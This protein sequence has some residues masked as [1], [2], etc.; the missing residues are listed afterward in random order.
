MVFLSGLGILQQL[1]GAE[2]TAAK[3]EEDEEAFDGKSIPGSSISGARGDHR[4]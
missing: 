4:E 2:K 3:T 1:L